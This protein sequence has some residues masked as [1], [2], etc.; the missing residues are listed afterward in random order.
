MSLIRSQLVAEIYRYCGDP[1]DVPLK[2]GGLDQPLVFQV[3]TECEDEMLRD[4][5]L[6]HQH[7]RIAM[8]EFPLSEGLLE[9][10]SI[11][12]EPAYAQLR[13]DS[14]SD[15]WWPVEIVNPNALL[16]AGIDGKLAVSFRDTPL[17]GETSWT[18]ES[19]QTLRIWSDRWGN[20]SPQMSGTT[21]LGNL[22][23]S[24]LKLRA[25]AQCR[26]LMNLPV[27]AILASRLMESQKQWKRHA[28][29]GRQEGLASK[30]MVFVPPRLRRRN[31][32]LD[33]SRFFLP[34]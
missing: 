30:P 4:L 29:K 15:L 11:E 2:Q 10:T 31:Y 20:D 6:S 28:A 17:V 23:D 34:R 5:A 21:D 33:P 1:E 18:P 19:S 16:D 14:S 12:G 7:R 24:F 32:L 3:L 25:A 27:G 9:F 22:Y 26:E 13:I 8:Q